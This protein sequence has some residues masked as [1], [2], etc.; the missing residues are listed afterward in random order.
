MAVIGR[1]PALLPGPTAHQLRG[2]ARIALYAGF[3]AFVVAPVGALIGIHVTTAYTTVFGAVIGVA[4]IAWLAIGSQAQAKLKSEKAA[5]YSTTID[6]AGFD[7]RHPVTGALLRSKKVAPAK[8]PRVSFLLQNFR[9]R[10]GT[11]A[12]DRL[13]EKPA[14]KPVEKQDDGG[15]SQKP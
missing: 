2:R 9:M 1:D 7:L 3:G 4:L 6:A 12:A 13:D 11:W 8:P 15:Q 10:P 14:D 5:G